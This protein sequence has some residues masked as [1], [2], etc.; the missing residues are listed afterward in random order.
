MYDY[1]KESA[2]AIVRN[3]ESDTN[4]IY[5]ES[6]S[7][8]EK[9]FSDTYP[10]LLPKYIEHVNTYSCSLGVRIPSQYIFD[11]NSPYRLMEDIDRNIEELSNVIEALEKT[12]REIVSK[13]ID[14][15]YTKKEI[16]RDFKL[17]NILEDEKT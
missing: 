1:H 12:K 3:I 16:R 15:D 10:K 5:Y 8:D 9:A 2:K 13:V 4:R 17:D 7:M 11:V 6:M 14:N